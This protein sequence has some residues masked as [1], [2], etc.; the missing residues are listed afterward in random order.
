[1]ISDEQ[2]AKAGAVRHLDSAALREF[3]DRKWDDEIV[4]AITD[5]IAV[6]AKIPMF[7]AN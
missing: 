7:D 2:A 5:Y 6:P 1:M 4:H 3:V